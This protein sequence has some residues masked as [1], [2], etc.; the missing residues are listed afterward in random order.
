MP[1]SLTQ[2]TER[3][4]GKAKEALE[5]IRKAHQPTIH[6]SVQAIRQAEAEARNS[7]A[8]EVPDIVDR[9]IQKTRL[10]TFEYAMKL[11][12][13]KWITIGLTVGIVGLSGVSWVV[14]DQGKSEGY[15]KALPLRE[16]ISHFVNCDEP[17]WKIGISKSGDKM[18]SPLPDSDNETYGWKIG[19]K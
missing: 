15:A 10:E 17:G 18:C 19:G 3:I 9:A 16:S 14:Y 4:K 2:H 8:Q 6:A 1:F 13:R 5:E 12:A 7:L 11:K